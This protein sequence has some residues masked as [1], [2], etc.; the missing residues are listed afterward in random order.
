MHQPE[1]LSTQGRVQ[2]IEQKVQ[3]CLCTDLVWHVE[4]FSARQQHKANNVTLIG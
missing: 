3:H 2:A 1:L 4:H